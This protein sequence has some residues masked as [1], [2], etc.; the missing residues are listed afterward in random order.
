MRVLFVCSGNSKDF[1]I[2]PFVLSQAKSLQEESVE[3]LFYKVIGKGIRGYLKNVK[4]LRA[5][6][7]EHKVDVIHA[8]YS[9]NG[10]LALLAMAKPPIVVSFMGSDTYGDYDS[11]GRLKVGSY[12][13]IIISKFIQPF[14]KAAIV[15]SPNLAKYIYLKSKSFIV[16]NGVNTNHFLP[17][18][19]EKAKEKLGLAKEINYA[20]FL[21]DKGNERKNFGLSANAVSKVSKSYNISLLTPYPVSQEMLPYYMSAADVVLLSSYNEGSPNVIKEAMVCNRP[22]VSTNVGDVEWLFG[23]EPGHFIAGFDVADYA[24]KLK[25]ALDFSIKNGSTNGRKR[26]KKLGLDS[27]TIAQRIISIYKKVLNEV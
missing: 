9:F 11:K 20:L 16:P 24:S 10:L 13:N 3:V 1:G 6:L 15:K 2:A 23:Y 21:G 5:F 19:N 25:L 17:I 12:I 22:I 7:R 14:I 4:K 27:Q 26:I 8:H 18:N